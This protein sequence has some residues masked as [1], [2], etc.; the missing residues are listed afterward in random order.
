VIAATVPADDPLACLPDGYYAVADPGDRAMVTYW[1][2]APSRYGRRLTAWPPRA[3][4]GPRL[5]RSEVPP[6]SDREGRA[7]AIAAHSAAGRAWHAAVVQELARDV[8]AAAARFA[9]L[10]TRCCCCGRP[11][12]DPASKTYGIGPECRQ[13][14]PDVWL[15]AM[16]DAV[17]RAH[18]E[19]LAATPAGDTD[20][21]APGGMYA[22]QAEP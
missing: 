10:R 11:L 19:R 18:G 13:G 6:A 7:A 20:P 16:A 1:R 15:A 22:D 2:V 8:A 14:L 4:Y 9:L 21:A 3:R 12:T 5:L 17:R